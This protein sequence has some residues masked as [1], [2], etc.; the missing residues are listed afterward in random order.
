[1]RREASRVALSAVLAWSCRLH[2]SP[3]RTHLL[4]PAT[5]DPRKRAESFSLCEW[6]TR[7]VASRVRQ[8]CAETRAA[9][10]LKSAR[11][12]VSYVNASVQKCSVEASTRPAG[13]RSRDTK[14]LADRCRDHMRARSFKTE[15]I[16]DRLCRTRSQLELA[17][18][19][20]SAGS[21]TTGSGTGDP[22]FR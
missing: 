13:L 7:N 9:R 5:L 15:L 12:N 3:F 14:A 21:T 4:A 2:S 6:G 22:W 19:D 11:D 20:T 17:V 18:V 8:R 1:M 10:D 16:A